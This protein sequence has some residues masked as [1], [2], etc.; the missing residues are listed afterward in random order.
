MEERKVKV[1]QFTDLTEDA[2]E[3]ARAW[4]REA[5]CGDTWFAECIIDDAKEIGKLMGVDI[6]NVYYSGF[7]SQGDGACFEGSYTYRKGAG[8]LVRD[9]APVDE[10][11]HRIVDA[12]TAA[13]RRTFY[14]L[15][16]SIKHSGHY[17]HEHCTRISVSRTDDVETT[18]DEDES[19]SEP[20]RDFMRW[21]Y[22]TLEKE[23]EYQMSDENVD[24]TIK[25]NEYEFDQDGD[26]FWIPFSCRVEAGTPA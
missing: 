11:L 7:W 23:Y 1:Y 16:A 20:L 9:Y 17:Y 8:K 4:F 3:K 19:I 2:K 22:R 26:R 12:L 15:E 18:D 10:E 5:C 21:I 14:R 13:Q 6:A 25:L 24:E